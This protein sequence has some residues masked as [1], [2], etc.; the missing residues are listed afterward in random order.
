MCN[1]YS[2]D[3]RKL[4]RF[5]GGI[6]GEEFSETR[7]PMR[8]GN[9]P[10]HVFPDR[11]GLVIRREGEAYVPESMR[12]GFPPPPNAGSYYVTN[13]RNVASGFWR[14]WLEP[15]WR[16]VVPATAFAEPDPEKPYP[17]AE[18]WFARTNGGPMLF[19]GIWRTWEGTRGTKK[20]P[21]TGEHRIFSFLTCEPNAV[22]KPI[23]PKAM[24]VILSP[25]GAI[26]WLTAPTPAALL[27]Q[28]PLPD[29]ELEIVEAPPKE[30]A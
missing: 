7:I 11:L 14:K 8:F 6:I 16:C 3:L 15:Q 12:W 24:P 27:L 28:K 20:E 5:L 9:L 13:V 23:H 25:Q 22:V 17:R 19:A 18:K 2:N 26:D 21:A 10:S 29:E 30:A 4:G 1:H